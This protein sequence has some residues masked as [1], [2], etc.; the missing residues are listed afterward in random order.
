MSLREKL[1]ARHFGKEPTP[2]QIHDRLQ[3]QLN[4]DAFQILEGLYPPTSKDLDDKTK[5]L[6]NRKRRK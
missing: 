3:Q 5:G 6:Q 1:M 2:K 4:Q